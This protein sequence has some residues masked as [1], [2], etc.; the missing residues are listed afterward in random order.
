MCLP[1]GWIFSLGARRLTW[2]V[3]L[4]SCWWCSVLEMNSL[5][6]HRAYVPNSAAKVYSL[7]SSCSTAFGMHLAD[8]SLVGCCYTL[9]CGLVSSSWRDRDRL[10]MWIGQTLQ[11]LAL[12]EK[13][14]WCVS[15][16]V[17]WD[18]EALANILYIKIMAIFHGL[19][20][21]WEVGIG[22]LFASLIPF[23]QF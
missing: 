5:L 2:I 12:D 14:K 21:Y 1:K 3:C 9:P 4:S 7:A 23:K 8:S 18:C 20:L 22:G 17:L 10:L 6:N 11:I 15:L 16:G 13:Q 19:S